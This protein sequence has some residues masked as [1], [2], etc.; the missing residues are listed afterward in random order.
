MIQEQPAPH[1]RLLSMKDVCQ[2]TSY[3]RATIYR[4]IKAGTFPQ[5]RRLGKRRV[6]WFESE[7][8]AWKAAQPIAD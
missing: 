8:E 2:E 3:H 5:R 6:G 7:I 4:H 1:G